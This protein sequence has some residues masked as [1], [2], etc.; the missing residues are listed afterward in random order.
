MRKPALTPSRR[1]ALVGLPLNPAHVFGCCWLLG[2]CDLFC[3][4]R[5]SWRC[6][7]SPPSITALFHQPSIFIACLRLLRIV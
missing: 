7:T 2:P 6:F 3:H 1:C 5:L 4:W